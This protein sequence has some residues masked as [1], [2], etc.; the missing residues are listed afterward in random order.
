MEEEFRSRYN[1]PE[2]EIIY[3]YRGNMSE[4]EFHY[5]LSDQIAEKGIHDGRSE[6]FTN[7]LIEIYAPHIFRPH[8]EVGHLYAR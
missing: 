4:D 8:L 5:M 6:E 2:G 1:I 7:A 3:V